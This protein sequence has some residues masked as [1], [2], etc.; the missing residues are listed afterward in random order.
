MNNSLSKKAKEATYTSNLSNLENR[1]FNNIWPMK[2]MLM[3]EIFFF[4]GIY[5]CQIETTSCL[6]FN[7][8]C[9]PFL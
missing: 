5:E 2:F 7:F 3:A 4:R 1:E 8:L 6:F 9:V